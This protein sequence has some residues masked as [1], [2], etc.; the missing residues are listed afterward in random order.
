MAIEQY[1]RRYGLIIT[2]WFEER[3]TAA[4]RGRPIFSQMLKLL[5]RGKACGVIIHK[6]DRSA[7]N[8]KDWAGLGEMIDAGVEVHFANESLDLNTRGGRLSADI[9][10]VVAADYIRNLREE[11]KKGFYGRL[12][13]G[14]YPLPAPIGYL[15]RGK[16]KPK[17]LDPVMG[18]LVAQAFQ[19][20]STGRYSLHRLVE[21]MTARGL[22]NR[23]NR[24]LSITGISTVLNNPF[25][26]GVIR[27]RK[28][29]ELLSGIH[30]P[31]I[32]KSLFDR[33]Q[34]ILSGKTVDRQTHHDL[35]FR[36]MVKCR[37]CNYSLIGERQK[38]HT[39]YR[40]HTQACF[41]KTIR[42]ER[43][44]TAIVRAFSL[45][46]LDNEELDH[47]ETWFVSAQSN[48]AELLTSGLQQCR[49]QLDQIR[50]RRDRLT[51]AYLD[52]TLD[53]QA[54][55][56]RRKSLVNEEAS[57]R[58]RLRS[59]EAGGADGLGRAKKFLELIKSASN[60]YEKANTAEKRELLKELTSNLTATAEN[61]AVTLKTEAELIATRYETANGVPRR[62]VRRTWDRILPKL[63]ML[64]VQNSATEFVSAN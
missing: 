24:K 13:Q 15:D 51:D 33:V 21:E 26:S 23:Q 45:L 42:E 29:G 3:E 18:P 31:L 37:N 12:K 9:Q 63:L 62:D 36:R 56:E 28:T 19:L 11:T 52:G 49:L 43:I 6:I 22:R 35:L 8:L 38:G 59:L 58:E 16:G 14:L 61:I 30:H 2:E 57:V 4:K 10:A 53:K 25:Y 41:R 48:Q 17:Q 50:S 46:N 1:A 40:C 47:V 32:G 64:F 44:N 60:L 20:Y 54:F 5:R 55:D 39:Y 34:D 27:I 7:R